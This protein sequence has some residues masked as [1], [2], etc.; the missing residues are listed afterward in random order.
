VLDLV[1]SEVGRIITKIKDNVSSIVLAVVFILLLLATFFAKLPAS[2][3]ASGPAGTP[4]APPE[5]VPSVSADISVSAADTGTSSAI[6]AFSAVSGVP[7]VFNYDI[8]VYGGTPAG[9]MAA[10]AAAGQGMDVALVEPGNHLGGMISGGLCCTDIGNSAVVGGLAK[11]FFDEIGAYYGS[12]KPVYAFEPHAAELVFGRIVRSAGVDVYLDRRLREKDGVAKNGAAIIS[13]ATGDGSIFLAKEFI[14][15]SYEGDLMAQAGVTYTVGREN[16]AQYNESLAGVRLFASLNAFRYACPAYGMDGLLMAGIADNIFLNAGQ[17]DRKLP[18]Y[19]FRLCLTKNPANMVPFT[20]PASYD[21]SQYK[22]LLKWLYTLKQSENGRALRLSDVFS[23]GQ[24]PGGKADVNNCGPVSTD[25]IGGSWDYPDA[26]YDK[27]G[28]IATH[29]REY[30][31]GLLYFLSTDP[32]V[33]AELRSELSQWGLAKDEFTDNRNWPYQ[34]YIRE[35]RRMLGGFVLTQKDLQTNTSKSDAVG[36]GSYPIDSHCVQRV[37]TDGG[38]AFNE[39]EIFVR[40]NPYQLPYRVLLPKASEASNLLVPVC[41]SASH[42]AYSSL[43]MEPQYMILG[44]AAG[45]AAALAA[46]GDTIVQKVNVKS[47]QRLL[48]DQGAVLSLR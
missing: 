8:V 5:S 3:A 13:I 2:A 34:L 40:V 6:P 31:M 38:L 1:R 12:A 43:R 35:S 45:L 32:A 47:L 42:V 10:A 29:H 25:L 28:D 41:V 14:D 33:P 27:R 20:Q 19:N 9:V 36:M 22:L 24:L 17:G 46:D 18:A 26:G 37:L 30:L 11:E 4:A 48:K 23:M 39:G 7:A 16:M 15:C 21:A 44:Q